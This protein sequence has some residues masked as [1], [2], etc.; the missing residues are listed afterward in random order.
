MKKQSQ[1]SP[2]FFLDFVLRDRI[3]FW[4]QNAMYGAHSIDWLIDWLIDSFI[5]CLIDWLTDWLIDWLIHR[6]IDW[7]IDWLADW[8]IDWLIDWLISAVRCQEERRKG[9]F[10]D[11]INAG[12]NFSVS[13]ILT[14]FIMKNKTGN[15]YRSSE[16]WLLK[17]VLCR[18]M[19]A[20]WLWWRFG[21]QLVQ[22]TMCNA[23][24]ERLS[25]LLI[26]QSIDREHHTVH[27]C[28]LFAVYPH[29]QFVISISRR[30]YN[31]ISL[32]LGF[33][34]SK[35]ILRCSKLINFIPLKRCH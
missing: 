35:A 5:D 20:E 7:L 28:F 11:S 14:S 29:C 17:N 3:Q 24:S 13:I 27:W 33:I 6:L 9:P 25:A 15:S 32:V 12:E 21:A 22:C 26:S 8:T 2:W 19:F 23:H 18:Q 30:I 10:Y 31:F 1:K 16:F 4:S 34:R